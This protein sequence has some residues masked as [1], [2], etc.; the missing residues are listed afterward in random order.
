MINDNETDYAKFLYNKG[1]IKDPQICKCGNS[2]FNIYKDS[3]SK[4]SQCIFRCTN[5]KCKNR[6]Q[7]RTNFFLMHFPKLN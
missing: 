1:Y 2:E 4:T 5:A 7:I 6:V 3:G